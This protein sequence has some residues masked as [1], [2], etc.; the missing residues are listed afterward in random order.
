MFTADITAGQARFVI[1]D[2]GRGFD[3]ATLPSDLSELLSSDDRQGR[4]LTHIRLFVDDVA[5]NERG[6]EI[7][8]VIRRKA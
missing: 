7:T 1:R 5:F 8:L 2:E 4:G 3:H 6:N